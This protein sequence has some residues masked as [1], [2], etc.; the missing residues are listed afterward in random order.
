MSERVAASSGALDPDQAPARETP[1]V[2]TAAALADGSGAVARTKQVI[3]FAPM[4]R[5]ASTLTVPR[6][7]ARVMR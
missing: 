7:P 4:R 6:R 1:V 5:R 2:V 3:W